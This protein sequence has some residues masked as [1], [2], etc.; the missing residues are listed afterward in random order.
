MFERLVKRLFSEEKKDPFDAEDERLAMAALLVRVARTDHRFAEEEADTI[1]RLLAKRYELDPQDAETLRH[2]AENIESQAPDTVQFT[3]AIKA[4]ID[5]D[6]RQGVVEDLWRVVL[7]DG[8]R[9]HEEDGFM[10]LA[11]NLLGVSD[12]DSARARQTAQQS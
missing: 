10:R 11:A 2:H 6:E 9:D 8:I 12:Q 3:R 1:T 7:A 5:Y 4:A